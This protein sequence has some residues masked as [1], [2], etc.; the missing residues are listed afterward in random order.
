M[1]GFLFLILGIVT[2]RQGK[3]D[4]GNRRRYCFGA[5]AR[6][7]GILLVSMAPLPILAW[8]ILILAAVGESAG[9]IPPPNEEWGWLGFA[10][11]VI[12]GGVFLLGCFAILGIALPLSQNLRTVKPPERDE[13]YK[14]PAEW[15]RYSEEFKPER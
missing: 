3:V 7:V 13:A 14:S 11:Y 8:L 12:D 4:F 9:L 5:P 1:S 15:S 10:P 6:I 2:L